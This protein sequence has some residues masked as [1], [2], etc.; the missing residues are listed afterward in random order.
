[1]FL[2]NS[3]TPISETYAVRLSLEL[4]GNPTEICEGI[5]ISS[6]TVEVDVPIT[7]EQYEYLRSQ[8][9]D[10]K[11]DLPTLTIMKGELELKVQRTCLN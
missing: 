8:I 7:P 2:K 3:K 10:S 9:E 1:M 5:S 4:R 11:E 6:E